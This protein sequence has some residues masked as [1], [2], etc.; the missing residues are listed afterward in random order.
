MPL[1]MSKITG[2]EARDCSYNMNGQ[3]HTIAIT[4]GDEGCAMCDTYTKY[5]NK[6]G[7]SDVIGA[8]GACREADCLYNQSLECNA[9]SIKV[10]MH[11]GH[12]DCVTYTRK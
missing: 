2:C 3:C 5:E 6:G 10:G 12:A 9:G 7:A 11:S 1:A 4:V 8:V